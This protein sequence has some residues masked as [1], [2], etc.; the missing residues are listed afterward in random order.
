[1]ILILFPYWYLSTYRLLSFIRHPVTATVLLH[2]SRHSYLYH[3]FPWVLHF[4]HEEVGSVFFENVGTYLPN[5]AVSYLR[6]S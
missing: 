6:R 1:M 4:Y 2:N 5:N 3:S